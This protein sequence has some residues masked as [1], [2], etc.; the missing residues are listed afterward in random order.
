MMLRYTYTGL[1]ALL[2]TS[3]AYAQLLTN[4]NSQ[5]P[6][7]ASTCTLLNQAAQAC[8]GTASANQA[9][10]ACFC[11]SAYLTSL[12]SSPTGICDAFCTNPT[13]N[14]Q[15]M[16]WFNSNCGQDNGAS[17]HPDSGTNAGA[18]TVVIT[19]TSSA[20]VGP[21]SANV[22][23]NAPSATSA[24][25]TV[26]SDADAQQNGSWFSNHWVRKHYTS[27]TQIYVNEY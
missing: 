21:S 25:G 16:T 19:S 26:A 8:G 10:W 27:R 17:E 15:V 9:I 24:S 12:K 18:T 3:F 23:S 11:Q 6:Q 13:D 20:V 7:C 2:C 5:F 1:L 14:Q 22:A 4:G